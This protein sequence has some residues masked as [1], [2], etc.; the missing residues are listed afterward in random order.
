M[1]LA[2]FYRGK[3]GCIEAVSDSAAPGISAF[4]ASK[5][6]A[7]AGGYTEPDLATIGTALLECCIVS[8]LLRILIPSRT[9][10][11]RILIVSDRSIA[12]DSRLA[13]HQ[14]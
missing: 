6:S 3:P 2:I 9:L 14:R 8:A 10:L 13:D 4:R 7:L 1:F 5:A 12:S 11:A